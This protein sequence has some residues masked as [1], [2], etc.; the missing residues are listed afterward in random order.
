[1]FHV[2]PPQTTNLTAPEGIAGRIRT[3]REEAGLRLTDLARS[4]EISKSYLSN[5]EAGRRQPPRW[6]LARI[7]RACGVPLSDLEQG[8]AA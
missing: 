8:R 4:V 7:A 1:M 6:L 5:I 2:M 3:A